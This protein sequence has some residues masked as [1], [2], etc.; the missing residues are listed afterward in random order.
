MICSWKYWK[1]YTFLRK[2][3]PQMLLFRIFW[4]TLD[5]C[6]KIFWPKMGFKN[7][8]IFPHYK[9]H[10]FPLKPSKW[11][12]D[13]NFRPSIPFFLHSLRN[14]AL[15]IFAIHRNCTIVLSLNSIPYYAGLIKTKITK[16][17][18]KIKKKSYSI[19]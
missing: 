2:Y 10:V 9:I 15:H 14:R 16:W 11:W 12:Q 5:Q 6:W 1:K 7:F 19:V 18:K 17:N 3:T 13:H 4:Y 8:M